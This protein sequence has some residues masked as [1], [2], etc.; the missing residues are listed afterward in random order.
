M[1]QPDCAVRG[2]GFIYANGKDMEVTRD[3]AA[4]YGK[5]LVPVLEPVESSS[6]DLIVRR[7]SKG[8]DTSSTQTETTRETEKSSKSD[9]YAL[10]RRSTVATDQPRSR[11]LHLSVQERARVATLAFFDRREDRRETGSD[12][13]AEHFSGIPLGDHPSKLERYSDASTLCCPRRL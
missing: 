6:S 13:V 5:R 8:D 4:P 7:K 3:P 2:L 11:E 1:G 12:A 9:A 10:R